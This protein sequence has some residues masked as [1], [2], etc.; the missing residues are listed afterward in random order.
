MLNRTGFPLIFSVLAMACLLSSCSTAPK[1]DESSW[2]GSGA[3]QWLS[4]YCSK[5]PIS[6]SGSVVIQANT[7]EFKGQHPASIRMENDGSFLLEVTHI[8]GGTL[9]R[10]RGRGDS[11]DLEAPSRP[12]YN[13]TGV[14]R[15]LG[16]EVPVLRALLQGELPCPKDASR[17]AETESGGP[18]VRVRDGEWDWYYSRAA[19]GGEGVPYAVERVLGKGETPESTVQLWIENWDSEGGFARKI[20]IKTADG[21]LK[22]IWRSREP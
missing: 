10:L 6:V 1:R 7:R 22:W 19:D 20:R 12:Q 13:R 11:F 5:G 4:K 21:E 16:L 15:Y 9:L 8:L 17:S 14:S 3:R 2:S 18:R